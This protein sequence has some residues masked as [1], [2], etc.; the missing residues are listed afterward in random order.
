VYYLQRCEAVLQWGHYVPHSLNDFGL[1]LGNMDM[2][3][4]DIHRKDA[5]TD[6]YFVANT[7]HYPGEAECTFNVA[8]MQ[9]E[10]WDPVSGSIRDLNQFTQKD[11]KTVITLNFEDAQ[12]FFIVFRKKIAAPQNALKPNFPTGKAIL[13]L[14]GP[15]TVK[16]DPVW[17]GPAQPV[18]FETLSDWTEN[19]DKGIKYY[20]GTAVYSRSFTIPAADLAKTHHKIYLDLGT[21]NCIARVFVNG[22]D[23]GVVWTAPWRVN[24]PVAMLQTSNEL[25]IEVTNVWA[26]RLIGDE[27]EPDDMKWLPNHY[28]YNSGQYLKEFPD[29][30]LKNEPRPSKGRYCFTTWNYFDSHSKLSR[31]G[32]LGP[33]TITEQEF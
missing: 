5:N 9:P 23:L 4:K 6:L 21:V 30:F 25:K 18:K 10:L 15:W 24:I 27:Q 14:D 1:K 26:N 22:K 19:K 13:A 28:F 2:V 16:F 3:I 11:S 29:W 20:S 33:V 12:S 7:S 31:S 17:G 32:L 8:G